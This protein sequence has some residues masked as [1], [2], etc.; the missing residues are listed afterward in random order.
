M[1]GKVLE[2][3][4]RQA[5]GEAGGATGRCL[6]ILCWAASMA[7]ACCLLPRAAPARRKA[8]RYSQ[9]DH[10]T[11]ASQLDLPAFRH[12][13]STF[14]TLPATPAPRHAADYMTKVIVKGRNSS[15]TK[16]SEIMT[17]AE[18]LFTVTPKHR[19]GG[20]PFR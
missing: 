15:S 5:P 19:W 16:V 6:F 1:Q 14:D 18:K 4:L 17:P 3:A 7:N 20:S 11:R 8:P 12:A 2:Y 10:T 9:P 13:H